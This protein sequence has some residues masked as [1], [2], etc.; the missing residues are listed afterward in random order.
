ML[1]TF[2]KGWKT[3]LFLLSTW[4]FY[5]FFGFEYTVVTI[6]ALLYASKFKNTDRIV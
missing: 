1:F 2:G 4:A 3:M 5:G 6:L